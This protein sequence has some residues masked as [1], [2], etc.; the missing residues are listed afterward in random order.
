VVGLGSDRGDV[1]ARTEQA[2]VALPVDRF[3]HGVREGVGF[4][5][6]TGPLDDLGLEQAMM[7]STNAVSK[8]SRT[9]P[10]DGRICASARCSPSAMERYWSPT[11]DGGCGR[12]VP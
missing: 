10:T 9:Y 2:P 5:A 1:S 8:A 12:G 6:R 11:S 4:A 7:G 3:E